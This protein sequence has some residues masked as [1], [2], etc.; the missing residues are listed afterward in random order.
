MKIRDLK[1]LI[2]AGL[3]IGII[4]I[5]GCL[6]NSESTLDHKSTPLSDNR[7]GTTGTTPYDVKIYYY[8][9]PKCPNCRAVEPYMEFIASHVRAEFDFCDLTS[10]DTCTNISKSLFVHAIRSL[11]ISPA[12]PM[13]IIKSGDEARVLLGRDKI[14]IL[15]RILSEEYGLSSPV[16]RYG[17]S[18]YN[19]SDCIQCHKAREL[20]IPSKYECTSCCH[21]VDFQIEVVDQNMKFRME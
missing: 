21:D 20:P 6:K 13:V 8:Y 2:V 12:V 19:L 15:D 18:E 9:D 14:S 3:M 10:P 1:V 5:T 11:N 16:F 7:T 4:F 17:D